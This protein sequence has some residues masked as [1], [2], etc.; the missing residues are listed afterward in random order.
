MNKSEMRDANGRIAAI[1][2]IIIIMTVFLLGAKL[3]D[4]MVVNN[5]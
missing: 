4:F 1:S 2:R 3:A 5:N